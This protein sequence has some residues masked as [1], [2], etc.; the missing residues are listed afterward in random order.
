MCLSPMLCT[1]VV[2]KCVPRV[3][4]IKGMWQHWH[5]AHGISSKR[6]MARRLNGPLHFNHS[7]KDGI[8]YPYRM[9]IVKFRWWVHGELNC[10]TCSCM[11]LTIPSMK[12][13]KKK[14][15]FSASWREGSSTKDSWFFVYFAKSAFSP[16]PGFHLPRMCKLLLVYPLVLL[17]SSSTSFKS[18]KFYCNIVHILQNSPI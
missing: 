1:S 14:N 5:M 10:Y 6:W 8:H 4:R 2:Y 12:G 16:P 11:C 13:F 7:V 3:I 15:M 18:F 9:I 17:L